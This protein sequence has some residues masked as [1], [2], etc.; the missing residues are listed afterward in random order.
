MREKDNGRWI[1]YGELGLEIQ[2]LREYVTSLHESIKLKTMLYELKAEALRRR[3][4]TLE[5]SE[6]DRQA[7]EVTK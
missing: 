5:M 7:H 2:Q 3:I 6:S 4:I 1:T